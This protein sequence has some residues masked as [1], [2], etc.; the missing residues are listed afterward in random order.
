MVL[1]K[2]GKILEMNPIAHKVLGVSTEAAKGK[3]LKDVVEDHHMLSVVSNWD[4]ETEDYIPKHIEIQAGNE[5]TIDTIRESSIVIEDENGR[6]IGGVS[7]LQDVVRQKEIESR[8]NDILDVLGHDLRTPLTV[9]K[10][11]ISLMA[12]SLKLPDKISEAQQEQ[13]LSACRR[14]VIRLEKLVNKILDVRQLETGKIILKRDNTHADRLIEDAALSLDS[15]AKD[16]HIAIELKLEAL[17]EIDC[18]SE[19]IYQ[20]I[21]NL[22]SNAL[23]F[24]SEGGSIRVA[25]RTKHCVGVHVVE[26]SVADSGVGIQE[27][28]LERIFNKYEQVS[29]QSPEGV[30]G[31]GLGL[32]TCKTIIEMHGGTIW[33]DSNLGEGST[34]TFQI[35][36]AA[37]DSEN[38]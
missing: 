35:P 18:D 19:R 3:L 14:N 34:F 9:V 38:S 1:G 12:D 16:K 26:I 23:K 6:P 11:S 29:L 15:W 10:Q 33:V 20:V 21:T 13:I 31:L 32:S 2:D 7:A 25:A 8:K 27:D 22:V 5:E 24:T 4:K 37:P 36:V 28:D 30:S 17:P